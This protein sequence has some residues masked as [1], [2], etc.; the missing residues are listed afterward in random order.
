MQVLHN[1]LDILLIFDIKTY[2]SIPAVQFE[3][4][5]TTYRL[6]TNTNGGGTLLCIREDIPSTLLNTNVSTESFYIEIN[7]KKEMA[8]SLHMQSK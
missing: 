5:Y 4:G 3:I 7:I 1:N 2:S 6:Y 8:S